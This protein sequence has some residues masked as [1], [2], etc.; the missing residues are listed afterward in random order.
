MDRI[1]VGNEVEAARNAGFADPN[2]SLSIAERLRQVGNHRNLRLTCKAAGK[3]HEERTLDAHIERGLA[4]DDSG[5]D[6]IEL[7]EPGDF[8]ARRRRHRRNRQRLRTGLELVA[9]KLAVERVEIP[10]SR[11]V[12]LLRLR[13]IAERLAGAPQPVLGA[14]DAEGAVRCLA[15]LS[16]EAVGEARVVEMPQGDPARQPHLLLARVDGE[17]ARV[18]NEVERDLRLAGPERVVGG[19]APLR[20]P[21]VRAD[22][23]GPIGRCRQ[24]DLPNLLL[25]VQAPQL[26][27]ALVGETPIRGRAGGYRRHQF[28]RSRGFREHGETGLGFL[29]LGLRQQR[30]DPTGDGGPLRPVNRPA[31]VVDQKTVEP[32]FVIGLGQELAEPVE[33]A[34]LQRR[35]DVELA[36]GADRERAGGPLVPLRKIGRCQGRQTGSGLGL[37]LAEGLLD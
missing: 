4:R 20:P 24:Q 9:C 23:L 5:S 21:I 25:L 11:P 28:D 29:L 26:L 33:K 8:L 17:I 15:H 32:P 12:A 18:A 27:D 30:H 35:R 36:P 19:S 6:G 31:A 16:E 10:R 22:D 14:R 2:R 7:I 37:G 34:L 1:G 13:L 3:L